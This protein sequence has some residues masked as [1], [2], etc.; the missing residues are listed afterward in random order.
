MKILCINA[1]YGIK[2]NGEIFSHLRQKMLK[3][4]P[5]KGGS[6]VTIRNFATGKNEKFLV[7]RLRYFHF[8]NHL[9]TNFHEMSWH[10]TKKT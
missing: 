5:H 1:A 10:N 3:P 2:K 9:F 7:N 8:E 4:T 6:Q